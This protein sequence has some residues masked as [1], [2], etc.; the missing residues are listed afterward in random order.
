MIGNPDFRGQGYGREAIQEVLNYLFM[1]LKLQAIFLGVDLK[2][3]NAISIYRNLGFS[4]YSSD[5]NRMVMVK[6][7]SADFK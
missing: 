2:N 6:R 7:V 1:S 5:K 3:D 4:E